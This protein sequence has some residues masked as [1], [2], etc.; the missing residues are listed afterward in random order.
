MD[1][2]PTICNI[3]KRKKMTIQDVSEKSKVAPSRISQIENNRANPSLETLEAIANALGV[4]VASFFLPDSYETEEQ[5]M[6]RSNERTLVHMNEGNSIYLITQKHFEDIQIT[7]RVYDENFICK[8]S[9]KGDFNG[10]EV[11]F[12]VS[13]ELEVQV[14]DGFYTLHTGDSICFESMRPHR[15]MGPPEGRAEVLWINIYKYD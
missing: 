5:I 11:V 3:R 8:P 14:G 15:V 12:A 4:N 9:P 6:L 7:Y 13:G 2:G 10:F 1:I